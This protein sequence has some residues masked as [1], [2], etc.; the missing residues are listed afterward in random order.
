MWINVGYAGLVTLLTSMAFGCAD[1]SW[2]ATRRKDTVAAYHQFL[3]D[4]PHSPKATNAEEQ[5]A[6]LRVQAIPKIAAFEEFAAKYPESAHLA[7]LREHLEPHYFERAR[8]ANSKASYQAFLAR[9]PSSTLTPKAMGNLVYID[10]VQDDP[11]VDR[12]RGFT[13]KYP[14]SDFAAEADKTLDILELRRATTIG[15]LAVRVDVAPNVAQPERVRRGFAAVVARHYQEQGVEVGLIPAG[16]EAPPDADAWMRLEYHEAPASGTF[17]GRTLLSQCRVRLYHRDSSEPVWDRRFEAPAD[18]I[19]QGAYGRDKTLF[20]N[21][22]YRFW[23]E[24]FVPVS[25]WAASGIRVHRT[26]FPED[27]SA[28]DVRGDRAVMLYARGGV[29][30]LDVSSPLE[31]K[32]L[33]RYRREHDLS[34]WSGIKLLTDD[35]IAM[36]GPDGLELVELGDIQARRVGRWELPEVGSIQETALYHHPAQQTLLF[37]GTRGVYAVRLGQRPLR[38]QRLLDGEYIGVYVQ[39]PYIYLVQPSQ[40]EVT[41]P[42]HLLQ[43]LTGLKRPLGKAFGAKRARVIGNSMYVFG[44][45]QVVEVSLATPGK[46]KIT[47]TLP[48]DKTGKVVDVTSDDAH[49]YLLGERGLEV[50]SPSGQWVSDFVQVEASESFAKKGRFLF[51]IGGRTLEVLDLGPYQVAVAS[52]ER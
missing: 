39:K 4:N 43:H 37:A 33:E 46:P 23:E 29:D 26:D 40:V 30:Y 15:R 3:R 12:L 48:G 24:F 21:S 41:T 38:A 42:K 14:D 35:L 50:A 45:E 32:V 49:L 6:Y 28:I 25:T 7:E 52:P 13:E 8:A 27:V 5:I 36:Y 22:T 34:R 18:H 31:P 20:A 51:L 44:K 2:E 10:S 19:I 11:S 47:A 16:G 1:T 9:Y 17:G